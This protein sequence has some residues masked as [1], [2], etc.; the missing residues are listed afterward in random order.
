VLV[1]VFIEKLP[2]IHGAVWPETDLG[3][4][5]MGAGSTRSSGPALLDDL[6]AAERTRAILDSTKQTY[7]DG[8]RKTTDLPAGVLG[9]LLPDDRNRKVGA[10][11]WSRRRQVGHSLGHSSCRNGAGQDRIQQTSPPT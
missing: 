11:W 4:Y 2:I 8:R 7:E 6:A 9:D 3:P 5:V 10:A 1:I